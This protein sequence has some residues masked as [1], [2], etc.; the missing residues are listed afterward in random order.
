MLPLYCT[1]H[2]YIPACIYGVFVVLRRRWQSIRAVLL[3]H[4]RDRETLFDEPSDLLREDWEDLSP[5][6]GN[7]I[8]K[9]QHQITQTQ[10]FEIL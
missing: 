7:V 9:L 6:E 10:M 1:F 4:W 2:L 5:R 8:A 3:Q